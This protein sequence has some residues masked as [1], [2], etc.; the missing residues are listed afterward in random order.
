MPKATLTSKGQL[1]LPKALRDRLDLKAGDP[2]DFTIDEEGRIIG[3]PI[4]RDPVDQLV[5]S[6][7]HLAKRK[8]VTVE[9]MDRA[10][11]DRFSKG[12]P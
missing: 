11:R 6:L 10:I 12:E 8:P 9:Q 5:G 1:T 2:I 3:V 4:I 7:H